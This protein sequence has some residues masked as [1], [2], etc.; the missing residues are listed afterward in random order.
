MKKP[1]IQPD[2]GILYV[3]STP[4][5]N[6]E[7]ITL[8]ALKILGEVDLIAA[9]SVQH[10]KTICRHYGIKTRLTSYNQH[11]QHSKGPKLIAK[12]NAG[13]HVALITNAGTP[14]ISDPGVSLVRQ[15]LEEKVK[16]SP[17]PGPSAVGAALSVSGLSTDRFL[18]LGFLS[19]KAGKRRKELEKLAVEPR[20]ILLYEAPHRLKRLLKDIAELLSDRDIVLL[21]EMTKVFEEVKRGKAGDLLRELSGVDVKGEC[22]LV[23]SGERRIRRGAVLDTETEKKIALLLNEKEYSMR[24]IAEQISQESGLPYRDIYKQCLS[25]K[26][27]VETSLK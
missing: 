23:V 26:K 1:S 4:I 9:E 13:C 25:I 2:N 27:G 14:C 5:G 20:T 8:R 11:N 6:L 22:T 19:S 24:D 16:V 3:V 15:A 17:I 10:S 18:F 21:R 12:L 7:D